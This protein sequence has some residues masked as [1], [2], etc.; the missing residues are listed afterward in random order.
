[1]IAN[2]SSAL[3]RLA[4]FTGAA[5]L[6]LTSSA[7]ALNP[8]HVQVEHSY[9]NDVSPPLRELSAQDNPDRHQE[10]EAAENPRDP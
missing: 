4:A 9:R 2:N 6:T 10:R 3:L 5:A 8:Q 1:M 7:L